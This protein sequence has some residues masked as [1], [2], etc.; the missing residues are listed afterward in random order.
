MY[1]V[2]GD[3]LK[4]MAWNVHRVLHNIVQQADTS[5]CKAAPTGWVWSPHDL[6][7]Q[8]TF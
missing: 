4:G 1:D 5:H 6:A 8:E 7:S 3:A 2:H